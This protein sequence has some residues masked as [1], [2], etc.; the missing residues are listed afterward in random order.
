VNRLRLERAARLDYDAAK[1]I[2]GRKRHF[3]VD[4]LGNLLAMHVTD[5]AVQDRG[6][7]IDLIHP[8]RALFP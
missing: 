7:D 6:A 1:K 5:G 3:L 4:C 8:V 2:N